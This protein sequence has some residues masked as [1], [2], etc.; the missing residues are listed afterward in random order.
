MRSSGSSPSNAPT[1]D[2]RYVSGKQS[3]GMATNF[4]PHAVA[5]S[6][7]W[8]PDGSSGGAF[9]PSPTQRCNERRSD[10]DDEEEEE[11]EEEEEDEE[12]APAPAAASAAFSR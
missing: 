10:D 8:S 7:A 1:R 4:S 5:T 12:P 11:E 9:G 6:L 2:A 3:S